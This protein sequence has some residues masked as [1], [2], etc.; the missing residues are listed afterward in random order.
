MNR[1][2][3][4]YVLELRATGAAGDQSEAVKQEMMRL[5]NVTAEAAAALYDTAR[6]RDALRGHYLQVRSQQSA[7]RELA[8]MRPFEQC[9][10]SVEAEVL[11]ELL[12]SQ[13]V[14]ASE[15]LRSLETLRRQPVRH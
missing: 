15:T 2:K 10:A 13:A 7:V 11:A 3:H 8:L 12:S 14:Q 1:S 4:L 9:G 6:V 5:A